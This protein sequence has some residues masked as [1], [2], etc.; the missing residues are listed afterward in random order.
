MKTAAVTTPDGYDMLFSV[1]EYTMLFIIIFEIMDKLI[2]LIYR[3]IHYRRNLIRTFQVLI[4]LIFAPNILAGEQLA[5][6]IFQPYW[7]ICIRVQSHLYI[8]QLAVVELVLYVIT[9]LPFVN[10]IAGRFVRCN[11]NYNF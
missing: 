10:T 2:V 3:R 11:R 5:E 6:I 8:A 7:L 4:R 9:Y 1:Q